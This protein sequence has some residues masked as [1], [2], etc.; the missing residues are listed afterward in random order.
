MEER[1]VVDEALA[2][3]PFFGSPEKPLV[4]GGRADCGHLV[5][6]GQQLYPTPE[7]LSACWECAREYAESVFRRSVVERAG[8]F[9]E[10]PPP[11]A[12][13]HPSLYERMNGWLAQW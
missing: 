8:R 2:F 1:A 7:F 12:F 6:A 5:A 13:C 4:R 10:A 11:T 3:D 9:G